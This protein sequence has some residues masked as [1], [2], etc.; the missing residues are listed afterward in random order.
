MVTQERIEKQKQLYKEISQKPYEVLK[1][2]REIGNQRTPELENFIF[3]HPG[4]AISYIIT[5]NN[6]M[7]LPEA[8]SIILTSPEH[9]FLYARDIIK[10]EWKKANSVIATDIDYSFFYAQEILKRV[11]PEAHDKLLSSDK[12]KDRYAA[13]IIASGGTHLYFKNFNIQFELK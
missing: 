9:C 10:G 7:P 4:A 5:N 3:K 8:E 11:F 1:R 2:A 12:Y 13:L 6:S